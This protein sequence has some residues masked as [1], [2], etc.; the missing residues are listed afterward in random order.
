MKPKQHEIGVGATEDLHLRVSVATYN[1]VVFPHSQNGNIMLALERKATVT[2]HA[3][4]DIHVW[5]QP[6]G[7]AVRIRNTL[8]LQEIVGE[9]QFDSERSKREHD[10]RILIPP[11]KWERVKGYCLGHLENPEDIELEASPHRE[12]V[13][14]FEETLNVHLSPDQYAVQPAGFVIENNP[15]PTDNLDAHRQPTV[16]IYRIFEARIVDEVL[17]ST[18]LIASQF[19]SDQELGVLAV[20]DFQNGGIG[21]AN[22]VLTLPLRMI[23]ESYRAYRPEM[24]YR[25]I[26]LENH[27]L[28]ESVLAVLENIDVPQYQRT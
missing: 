25:K 15:V 26:V 18:M 10:F 1:R 9:I 28:D 23:T 13:E 20:K 11:S 6:F 21:R 22:S 12:L 5:A 14:E 3:G 16:R 27:E 2:N 19:N 24:R 7:G 17:C 8:P 4:D